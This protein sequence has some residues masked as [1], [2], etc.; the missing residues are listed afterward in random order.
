MVARPW[1]EPF[2]LEIKARREREEKGWRAGLHFPGEKIIHHSLGKSTKAS[3]EEKLVIQ[4]M[5]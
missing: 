5:V 4:F 3:K 2:D 1:L